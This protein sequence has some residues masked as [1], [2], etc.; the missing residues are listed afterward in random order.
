MQ[1]SKLRKLKAFLVP[2][3]VVALLCAAEAGIGYLIV[4][5]NSATYL[6]KEI[7]EYEEKGT[8]AGIVFLG[9][10]R[11]YHGFVPEIFEEKLGMDL[12][13][14]AGSGTQRPESSYYLLKDL[15]ERVHPKIVV[16]GIQWNGILKESTDAQRLESAVTACDRAFTC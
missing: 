7:S 12:V 10:S 14:N 13:I 8:E 3:L 15:N 5:V 16:L 6:K 4:P 2:I 11:V 9:S 1:T